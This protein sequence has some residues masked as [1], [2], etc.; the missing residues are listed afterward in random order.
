MSGE[1]IELNTVKRVMKTETDIKKK[2]K[3]EWAS[4]VGLC[5][6]RKP[7]HPH[8]VKVSPLGLPPGVTRECEH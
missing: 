3:K 2:N 8:H 1:F 5:Q 6:R 4:S 7:Q